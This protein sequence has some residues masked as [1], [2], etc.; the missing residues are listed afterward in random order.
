MKYSGLGKLLCE[1]SK[2]SK[3]NA[4]NLLM[5]IDTKRTLMDLILFTNSPQREL[6]SCVRRVYTTAITFPCIGCIKAHPKKNWF[7]IFIFK[8]GRLYRDPNNYKTIKT[9]STLSRASLRFCLWVFPT[10]IYL[11]NTF[12]NCK[13]LVSSFSF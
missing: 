7:L 10:K 13:S 2:L 12:E 11:Y 6:V 9:R 3:F 5:H 1:L 8:K 4:F